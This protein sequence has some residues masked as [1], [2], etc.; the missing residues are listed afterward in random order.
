MQVLIVLL[1][2]LL[3]S[4]SS[5]VC[6]SEV[7]YNETVVLGRGSIVCVRFLPA[8]RHS[9]ASAVLGWATCKDLRYEQLPVQVQQ[10]PEYGR[11]LVAVQ[12]IAADEVLL[13]VPTD[14]VFASQV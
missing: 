7:L 13:S 12:D 11:C 8:C 1:L 4:L 3:F 14:R 10:H 9:T 5:T 2:L 6:N